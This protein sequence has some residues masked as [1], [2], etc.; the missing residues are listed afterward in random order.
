MYLSDFRVC[1]DIF[2]FSMG[3]ERG[4]DGTIRPVAFM[5]FRINGQYVSCSHVC[6]LC[7]LACCGCWSSRCC[8]TTGSR[9]IIEGL[10]AGFMFC[11]GAVGFIV[12]DMAADKNKGAKV[13]VLAVLAAVVGL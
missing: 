2:F 12:L 6:C 4:P 3:Q 8:V 7:L 13:G 5:P 1:V 10:T 11:V 9:Y